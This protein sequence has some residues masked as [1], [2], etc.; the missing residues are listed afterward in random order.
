MIG[1]FYD[2]VTNLKSKQEVIGFFMGLLTPSE[3]L[4]FARRIQIAQL[5]LD[6][7]SYDD[8]R[9][10]LGVGAATVTAVSRWLYDER[11][12]FRKKIQEHKDRKQKNTTQTYKRR[13][14]RSILD[15]YP[16]HRILKDL[17][18]W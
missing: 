13:K 14:Y 8:I 17:F 3:A 12:D 7:K 11:E 16:E 18:G 15:K 6:E 2:I 1:E 9:K 5:L 4:M 10:A